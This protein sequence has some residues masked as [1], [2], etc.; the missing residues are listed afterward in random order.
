MFLLYARFL[1]YVEDHENLRVTIEDRSNLKVDFLKWLND[2][3][4]TDSERICRVFFIP[5]QVPV[6]VFFIFPLNCVKLSAFVLNKTQGVHEHGK[7]YAG[8]EVH[9]L[10]K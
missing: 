10:S 2:K 9:D 5:V 3:E 7:N 4:R 6:Q 1:G 8:L